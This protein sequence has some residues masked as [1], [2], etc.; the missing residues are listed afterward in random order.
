MR[1]SV[2]AA[3]ENRGAS[4]ESK[5]RRGSKVR[6]R[7][8]S[9]PA[10]SLVANTLRAEAVLQLFDDARN[11]IEHDESNVDSANVG[12]STEI[13][14]E[15]LRFTL[16]RGCFIALRSG[17][18]PGAQVER[19]DNPLLRVEVLRHI[20]NVMANLSVPASASSSSL[21][22]ARR[23]MALHEYSSSILRMA[24]AFCSP[25][26]T[27]AE[28]YCFRVG[29]VRVDFAET[30]KLA[31]ISLPSIP[32]FESIVIQIFEKVSWLLDGI[33]CRNSQTFEEHDVARLC[34]PE[35][36]H[37]THRRR[38]QTHSETFPLNCVDRHNQFSLNLS[39][40]QLSYLIVDFTKV[41]VDIVPSSQ[42][43]S[44]PE[45][46]NSRE[47]C[48]RPLQ[49][50]LARP[51]KV[52]AQYCFYFSWHFRPG[53]ATVAETAIS[54]LSNSALLACFSSTDSITKYG[55]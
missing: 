40:E 38:R 30:I 23:P 55:T 3:K 54:I 12:D 32:R 21:R 51:C 47:H 25:V 37:S 31:H 35:L 28:R 34:R 2:S 9:V 18:F 14:F 24:Q 16:I 13:V 4:T 1:P 6:S 19:R 20:V 45:L 5:Y 8:I 50:A 53:T 41:F 42:I 46:R 39:S 43:C 44:V 27:I 11:A 29:A 7:F 22:T 10:S 49:M 52:D 48:C 26:A 33:T 36:V 15:R 17:T